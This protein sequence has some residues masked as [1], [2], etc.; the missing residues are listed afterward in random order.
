MAPTGVE[1]EELVLVDWGVED[2]AGG[3]GLGWMDG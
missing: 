1:E 3:S 2:S